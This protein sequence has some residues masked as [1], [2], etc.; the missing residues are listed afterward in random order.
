LAN[1]PPGT[2]PAHRLGTDQIGRDILALMLF[3][4]RISMTVGLLSTGIAM[5]IGVVI[6][7]VSGYFGGWI[8]ILLQ[9]IVEIMMTFPA[10][11]LILIVVSIFGRNI[12]FIVAVIGLVGW[13]G[14]ARLTRGE[15]LSQMGREYVLACQALGLPRWRIMFRHILPNALTPLLI[16]ASFSI[17][18]AVLAESGLAFLG[19]VEST[20]PS[21]GLILN[22]GRDKIEYPHLLYAPGIAIFILVYTLNTIGNGLREAF[23]PRGA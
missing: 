20:T 6:G 3:G 15:F 22:S 2:D 21:W 17:A 1:L 8:D 12:F 10:F 4:A 5:C 18:G 23:D 19:L 7:A 16:A 14:T 11:I 13:A 9:R